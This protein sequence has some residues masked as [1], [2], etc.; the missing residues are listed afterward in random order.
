MNA[1][2]QGLQILLIEDEERIRITLA[3][4]LG[5]KGALVSLAGNAA[6]AFRIAS[7]SRL[8][9]ILLDL[10][11]PDMD[12]L[13]LI[14]MLCEA[15]GAPVIVISARDQEAQKVVA[16][17]EGADDYLT[18]PFGMSELLARI[19]SA[20]RRSQAGRPAA[21]QTRYEFADLS[22]D[23]ERHQVAVA[24]QPVHLTPVE[25]KLLAA[26]A[27]RAGKVITHRQ[28]LRDVWGPHHEEDGHY[29]RI[30]MRQLRGKLEQDPA[31]PRFLLTEP[32]VGYRL[33]GD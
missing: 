19:R 25:F 18:K 6:D 13:D 32:G 14:P 16:L 20:L 5:E 26:L 8:D 7:E 10:G 30:Y 33:A 9:L 27:R 3:T 23:V 17:D 4:T 21:E 28:L 1:S 11:L 2:M 15:S 31:Q 12:G 24:G 22:I 29:L